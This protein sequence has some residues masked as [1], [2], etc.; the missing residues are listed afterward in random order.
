MIDE[1]FRNLQG[2]RSNSLTPQTQGLDPQQY[3]VCGERAHDTPYLHDHFDP[4]GQCKGT[5]S[6]CTGIRE[7][8]R[9]VAFLR[10][11]GEPT[12]RGPVKVS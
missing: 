4:E 8:H 11:V 2:I 10:E 1:E 7:L 6:K 5:I 9:T 12:G 3:L